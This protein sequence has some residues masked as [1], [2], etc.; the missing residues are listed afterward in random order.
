M[1]Q[2]QQGNNDLNKTVANLARYRADAKIA[3]IYEQIP[4]IREMKQIAALAD[5]SGDAGT[6]KAVQA[7]LGELVAEARL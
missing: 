4:L 1:N 6:A 3:T 5:L 2:G 7:A